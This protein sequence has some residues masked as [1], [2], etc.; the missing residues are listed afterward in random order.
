MFGFPHDADGNTGVLVFVD[1]LSKMV[2]LV[3]VPETVDADMCAK[4]FMDNVFRLHGLPE[5][6]ISDRDPR[7]TAAFWSTLFR[8]LGTQLDM[9]TKDHPETDGQT[10]RILRGQC[11]STPTT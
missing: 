9:A 5:S 3:A 4:L 7:F 2:H 10:E 11:A 1:R 6:I 8:L